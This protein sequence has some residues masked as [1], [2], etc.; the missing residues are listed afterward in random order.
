MAEIS[1][2]PETGLYFNQLVAKP[3]CAL[4]AGHLYKLDNPED[5]D[6]EEEF[7]RLMIIRD[8]KWIHLGDVDPGI[9]CG[10]GIIEG[11]PRMVF[12]VCRDG[13]VTI[14]HGSD[15]GIEK[16]P[17]ESGYLFSVANIGDEI[18]TCGVDTQVFRRESGTWGR[19]D[20]GIPAISGKPD[21][22]DIDGTVDENLYVVG[23]RGTIVRHSGQNWEV[24][25]SPTNIDL[26][27]VLC[28]E[29]DEIYICGNKGVVLRGNGR[30]WEF[31]GAPGEGPNFWGLAAF[32]GRIYVSGMNELFMVDDSALKPMT[33]GLPSGEMFSRLAGSDSGLWAT[34]GTGYIYRYDG[35]NWEAFL[36]P[37]N[38]G[39]A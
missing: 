27:R 13:R 1:K 11:D 34:T 6:E 16:I 24:L 39:Q 38:G 9:V 18:Y 35:A 12:A 2:R 10:F 37:D 17:I 7:S 28:V 21:L 25:D 15:T 36:C 31:L 23:Q 33:T 26:H 8:S 22:Y 32:E 5:P 30:T 20:Q 3:D 29:P 4:A 19:F 14:R